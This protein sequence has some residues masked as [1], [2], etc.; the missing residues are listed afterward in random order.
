MQGTTN[1]PMR[2]EKCYLEIG[3]DETQLELVAKWALEDAEKGNIYQNRNIVIAGPCTYMH[4]C[5]HKYASQTW[6][7]SDIS[8]RFRAMAEYV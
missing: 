6:S 3:H 7:H 1:A 4:L 2:T 5:A 8:C